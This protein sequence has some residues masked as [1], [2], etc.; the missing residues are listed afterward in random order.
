VSAGYIG[1]LGEFPSGG[2]FGGHHQICDRCEVRLPWFLVDD[3]CPRCGFLAYARCRRCNGQFWRA[4]D[5]PV[6]PPK[7][8]ASCCRERPVWVTL[9]TLASMYWEL[10]RGRG[11]ADYIRRHEREFLVRQLKALVA[12]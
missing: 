9:R 6:A 8:H 10:W 12:R 1:E 2:C 3:R 5:S 11:C 4:V 7:Y